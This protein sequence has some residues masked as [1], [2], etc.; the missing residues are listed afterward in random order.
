M[1]GDCGVFGQWGGGGMGVGVGVGMNRG[2]IYVL[3]SEYRLELESLAYCIRN[4]EVKK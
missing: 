1:F 3:V 2:R 4:R